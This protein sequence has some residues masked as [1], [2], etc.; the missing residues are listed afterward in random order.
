[1]LQ[2]V[3]SAAQKCQKS[4]A[5]NF[6]QGV[7]VKTQKCLDIVAPREGPS[8]QRRNANRAAPFP[9]SYRGSGHLR[10]NAILVSPPPITGDTDMTQQC[11]D[12]NP[13]RE[14]P[15]EVRRNAT[16]WPPLPTSLT[17]AITTS[18]KCYKVNA[19]RERPTHKCSNAKA[20]APLST[21]HRGPFRKRRNARRETPPPNLGHP[22]LAE[23][24]LIG[25]P[26]TRGQLDSAAMPCKSRLAT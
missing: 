4:G 2:G 3:T 1:M 20:K 25:R 13:P 23:V 19:P 22:R 21:N 11:L 7:I 14:R 12:H 5:P 24:S 8:I 16:F 9:T 15:Y 10:S 26:I 6:L 18:Q 17:G